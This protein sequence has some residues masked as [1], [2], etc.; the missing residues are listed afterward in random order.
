M[1]KQTAKSGARKRLVT[2]AREV[3][4]DTAVQAVFM[5]LEPQHNAYA[6]HAIAVIGASYIEKALELSIVKRLGPM[7]DDKRKRLS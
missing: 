6:D 1:G 3:P 5:A 7:E 4:P 2:Y